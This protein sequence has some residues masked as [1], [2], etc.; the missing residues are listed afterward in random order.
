MPLKQ[1]QKK[2]RTREETIH[3]LYESL[4]AKG[5]FLTLPPIIPGEPVRKNQAGN[6]LQV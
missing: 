2:E 4:V 6:V 5:L 3:G 1:R